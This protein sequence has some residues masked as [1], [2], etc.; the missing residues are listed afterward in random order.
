MRRAGIFGSR[1]SNEIGSGRRALPSMKPSWT[2][3]DAQGW[4]LPPIPPPA[5]DEIVVQHDRL[6]ISR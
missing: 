1:M 6:S 3:P 4:G 5:T 2:F